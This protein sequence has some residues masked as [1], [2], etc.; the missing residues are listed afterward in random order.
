MW[1]YMKSHE[2]FIRTALADEGS[3]V[4]WAELLAFHDRQLGA[5]QHERLIHLIVM[6]FVA[7]FFLLTCGFALVEPSTPVTAMAGLL[8]LLLCAYIIHYFRLENGVQRWY[9]L[10]NQLLGAAGQTS[11]SYERG[12]PS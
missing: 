9:H 4:N 8:L 10:A 1:K 7:T 12:R 3:E 11:T 2:A 5:M 6:L